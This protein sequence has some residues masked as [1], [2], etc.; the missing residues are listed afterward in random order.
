MNGIIIENIVANAKISQGFNIENLVEKIPDF[1]YN[2]DD[3]LGATFKLDDP[4]TAILIL[5]NG[6]V[7]CTGA[8][9]IEEVEVSIRKL[10]EKMKNVGIEVETNPKIET[11]NIIVSTDLNKELNLSFISKSLM[12][13][14]VNYEPDQFPGLIYNMDEIRALLLI[15]SSGKIVC[16]GAKSIEDASKGIEMMKEKL[17][18]IGVL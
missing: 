15:F 8:T 12:L 18:S 17:S 10:I 1:I 14:N 5:S 9:R 16:T 13:K 4:K 2:P 6:K 7:I 11:Q 3:F